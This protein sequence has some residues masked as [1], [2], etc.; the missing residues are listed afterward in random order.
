VLIGAAR[1]ASPNLLAIS[2]AK[3]ST[4]ASNLA[5]GAR[6]TGNARDAGTGTLN[7]VYHPAGLIDLVL[8]QDNHVATSKD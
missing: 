3:A 2:H 5:S 1:P 6:G 7:G 8:S 4:P